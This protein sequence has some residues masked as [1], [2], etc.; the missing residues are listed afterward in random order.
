MC[1]SV[2]TKTLSSK[3]YVDNKTLLH[4]N[5]YYIKMYRDQLLMFYTRPVP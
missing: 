2:E 5:K 4:Q 1:D 3:H